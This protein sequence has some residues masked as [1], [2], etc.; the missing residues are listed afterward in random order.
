MSQPESKEQSHKHEIDLT[1]AFDTSKHAGVESPSSSD[2]SPGS[3]EK[4]G[5][6]GS[7]EESMSHALAKASTSEI[8]GLSPKDYSSRREDEYNE[9]GR[10]KERQSGRPHDELIEPTKDRYSQ[11]LSGPQ[12]DDEHNRSRTDEDVRPQAVSQASMSEVGGLL[13]NNTCPRT[14]YDEQNESMTEA[15][16]MFPDSVGVPVATSLRRS[17]LKNFEHVNGITVNLMEAESILDHLRRQ[18]EHD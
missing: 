6:S 3:H 9:S 11:A 4:H 12:P 1:S 15:G 2:T 7:V 8:S 13:S 17:E 18:V 10:Y 16:D 14:A 5:E